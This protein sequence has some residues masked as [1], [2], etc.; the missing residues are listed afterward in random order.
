MFVRPPMSLS[1][2]RTSVVVG[3]PSGMPISAGD[4]TL[5][6]SSDIDSVYTSRAF[7][8][9]SRYSPVNHLHRAARE[10]HLHADQAAAA[11]AHIHLRNRDGRAVGAIPG[12]E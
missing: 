3:C 8:T 7:S 10:L 5:P 11:D 9:T 4:A 12:L 1:S 2:T 6:C